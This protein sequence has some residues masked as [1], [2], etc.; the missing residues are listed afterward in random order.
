MR[1]EIEKAFVDNVVVEKYLDLGE[2]VYTPAV[3]F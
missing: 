2:E 3:I 1:V